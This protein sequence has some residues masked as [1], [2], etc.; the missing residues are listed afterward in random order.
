MIPQIDD[1]SD[2]Y[3]RI[4]KHFR[5][6]GFRDILVTGSGGRWADVYA[7]NPETKSLAPIEAKTEKNCNSGEATEC[8]YPDRDFYLRD[9]RRRDMWTIVKPHLPPSL[10][11]KRRVAHAFAVTIWHQFYCYYRDILEG[12][13]RSSKVREHKWACI[14]P[15]T[16]QSTE[17]YLVV[18]LQHFDALDWVIRE[19]HAQGWLPQIE[20]VAQ[21]SQLAMAVARIFYPFHE[22]CDL[23]KAR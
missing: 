17:P 23:S 5:A 4:E 18:P 21:D 6:G 20:S 1:A 12:Q 3:K 19:F 14:W 9:M 2:L 15:P 13:C 8:P 10:Q 11:T 16:F 7:C 22:P